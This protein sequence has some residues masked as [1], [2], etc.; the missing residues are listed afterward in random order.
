MDSIAQLIKVVDVVR[1]GAPLSSQSALK[2]S[3]C[4]RSIPS[5]ASMTVWEDI[6]GE[7]LTLSFKLNSPGI[8]L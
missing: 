3:L 4:F 7:Y 8:T 5:T 2:F 6:E 1:K